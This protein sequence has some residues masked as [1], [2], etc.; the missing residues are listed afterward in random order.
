MDA[1]RAPTFRVGHSLGCKLL[2]LVASAEDASERE[3]N[4]GMG[5]GTIDMDVDAASGTAIAVSGTR[6]GELGTW[7]VIFSS[8]LIT[9]TRPTR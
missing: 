5:D 4:G 6:G 8:R 7:R 2:C 1:S 3:G 9:P